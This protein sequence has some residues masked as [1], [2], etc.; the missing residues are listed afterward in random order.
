MSVHLLWLYWASVLFPWCGALQKWGEVR[1]KK[2]SRALEWH[3]AVFITCSSFLCSPAELGESHSRTLQR[4]SLRL[5][6][7]SLKPLWL[8]LLSSRFFSF[9]TPHCPPSVSLPLPLLLGLWN[10]VSPWRMSR[11]WKPLIGI[12]ECTFR[13]FSCL[14]GG[15]K[16]RPWKRSRKETGG[17]RKWKDRQKRRDRGRPREIAH[18]G[19]LCTLLGRYLNLGVCVELYH[20]LSASSPPHQWEKALRKTIYPFSLMWRA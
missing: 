4:S 12:N 13:S 1:K 9:Y 5:C 15:A 14:L 3:P 10:S 11:V 16:I 19:G 20:A 2:L 17:S 6:S 7:L 8:V 18:Q